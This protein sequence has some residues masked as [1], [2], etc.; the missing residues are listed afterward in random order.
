MLFVRVDV[1]LS[2]S[3]SHSPLCGKARA[4][5]IA[6]VFLKLLSGLGNRFWALG[7]IGKEMCSFGPRGRCR[8]LCRGGIGGGSLVSC[9]ERLHSFYKLN[10]RNSFAYT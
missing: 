2:R 4:I 3:V 9:C 1:A 5:S 6:I 7:L 10:S 8:F